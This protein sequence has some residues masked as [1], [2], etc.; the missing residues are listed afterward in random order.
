MN[1]KNMDRAFKLQL[2]LSAL[3]KGISKKFW[4]QDLKTLI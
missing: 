4:G 3:L 2:K 1:S